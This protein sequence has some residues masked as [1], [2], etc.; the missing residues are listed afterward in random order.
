[1]MSVQPKIS[2]LASRQHLCGSSRPITHTHTWRKIFAYSCMHKRTAYKTMQ[3]TWSFQHLFPLLA[4]NTRRI[5]INIYG[6]V[7]LIQTNVAHTFI[8]NVAHT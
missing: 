1:V 5:R 2:F 7:C 3:I 4:V 8:P 6:W